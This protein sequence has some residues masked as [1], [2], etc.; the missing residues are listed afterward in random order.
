[1]GKNVNRTNF[2]QKK[3][4][5]EF[6]TWLAN[7]GDTLIIDLDI[8]NSR[9]VPGGKKIELRGMN[10]VLQEYVWCSEATPSGD[11]RETKEHLGKL[12]TALK[13]AL[14]T[15]NEDAVM[16]TCRQILL[17]GGD[18]NPK[19]GASP[20]L[21]ALHTDKKLSAYLNEA[22][23]GFALDEA[24]TKPAHPPATRMNSMLTK[25]H[26][27]AS[28]DGLPIYDSRVAAAVAALV[29][30]W[31]RANK[32]QDE[33][34]PDELVFPATLTSRTVQHLFGDATAPGVM[35]YAPTKTDR[36]ARQWSGAKI[37]LAWVMAE[38]L[39]KAG[40]LF[41]TEGSAKASDR[42][43]AF[44][45]TLFIIGYDV[46]C[47]ARNSPTSG[48]APKQLRELRAAAN[49]TLAEEQN[50][51]RLM[52][53]STLARSK[54][55]LRYAGDIETGIT[56]TWGKLRFAFERDF[57]QEL[58][59]NFQAKTNV[60]LG[61]DINGEGAEG[62][63]GHWINNNHPGLAPKYA[64]AIAAILVNEGLATRVPRSWP[65]Q[66]NFNN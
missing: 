33:A 49:R 39:R 21:E 24:D 44:E 26:A 4:V 11:W 9:F 14:S 59:G 40:T 31:R 46:W 28:D 15:K 10:A 25:V 27:L 52:T 2:L 5:A 66:L 36:T 38:V 51:L 58:L 13:L 23:R 63:L 43:H 42:M 3:E 12:S 48:V 45:A 65:I 17:W 7:L 50:E 54:L 8:K 35:S 37:R 34:L 16:D 32:L 55:N 64:S 30:L 62:T 22:K 19:I 1:M 57:L 61:A 18:R 56:G 29:E 47:L 41:A 6:T 60:E 53:I 20:F